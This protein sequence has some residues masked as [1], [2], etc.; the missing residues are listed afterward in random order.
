MALAQAYNLDC[1]LVYQRQWRKA[2][3]SLAS[4]QDYLSKISKRAWVLHEC[5]ERVPHSIDAMKVC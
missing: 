2:E 5:L 4:I 3:V 1:D